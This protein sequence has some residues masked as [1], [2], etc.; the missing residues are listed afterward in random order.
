VQRFVW[1]L[2]YQSAV[3]IKGAK[4]EGNPEAAPRVRPGAYTVRLVAGKETVTA[5]L[6]VLPDP[7]LSVPP[8]DLTAQV[9]FGRQVQEQVTRLSTLVA[10]IR[11]VRQQLA[12]RA[13]ALEGNAAAGEWVKS[14]RDLIGKCDALEDKLHNPKATVE[15]D[16]LAKGAR[17]YSRL[18]PLLGFVTDGTGAPTEGARDVFA[19][20]VR[21][22]DGLENEWKSLV[23]GDLATLD[24]RSHELSLQEVIVPAPATAR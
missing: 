4:S 14:A 13:D 11:S 19:G 10:Q 12:V 21:E 16:V 23:G 5:P 22:L 15:Y 2:S 8:A 9:D 1:D 7:R 20:H 6:E 17:L 3:K 24:R 18:G